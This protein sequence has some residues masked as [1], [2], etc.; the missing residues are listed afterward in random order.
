V[1]FLGDDG[2][3]NMRLTISTKLIVLTVIT[4]LLATVPIAMKSSEL[5]EEVSVQREE[6]GNLSTAGYKSVEIE[7]T[8]NSLFDKAKLMGS[9][10][11]KAHSENREIGEDFKFNFEKDRNFVFIEVLKVDATGTSSLGKKV[12]EDFLRSLSLPITYFDSLRAKS[13]FPIRSVA[14]GNMEIRNST[15]PQG[16]PVFT[17]GVPLVKNE[18]GQISHI[19]VAEIQLGALQKTFSERS[20][21]I[22]YL[23]DKNGILLAHQDESQTLSQTSLKKYPLVEKSLAETSPKR[24][25]R[26][27]DD[28]K[29]QWFIGAYSKTSYGITVLTQT[30]EDIILEPARQVKRQAFFITGIV[31]S[32]ALFFI[33]L[34]SMTLTSP[35]EK[36]ASLI[37]Q[38]SKGNF[39]VKATSQVNSMDEVGDLAKAFDQMTEGLKE[40]D[41][42]KSLFSKFHGSSVAED[43]INNDVVGTGG[44]SKDVTVF[45]SDIRGFT[46]FSEKHSPEEVVT[47]LNEYFAVM[48]DIINRNN[49]IVDKFIGDAIMAVWGAP[50][51]TSAD[52]YNAV[53][54]C[55]EMRIGLAKLNEK[56]IARGQSPI[57]IGMGLHSGKA[58]SGTI[59]SD[60]RLEYTVIGDTVNMASRIEASTKAFGVDLLISDSTAQKVAEKF[61]IDVAGSAEVKGKA[62]A[63]K[64]Y[65][66]LGIK[67]SSGEV[68]IITTPY[69]EYKSEK[70]D[71]VKVA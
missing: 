9:L 59:G 48:V 52:T 25:I 53:K 40:R 54:A 1:G 47:M 44:S 3:S 58:I 31:L 7:N 57:M 64:L 5:F 65:K 24:Q 14:L 67:K 23:I 27:F 49:G 62:E 18:T 51:S 41:K 6:Y 37:N 61:S 34:F 22:S 11:Y 4:L 71:K 8:L 12:R 13:S 17:I 28:E 32:A 33:F 35:I 63:L 36:L 45:F 10:I 20:E 15:M 56:R 46:A 68:D 16:A 69:S 66:V 50:K 29:G 26:F 19:V 2:E 43:L 21:K 39:E 38:V 55:I 30:S 42:V 60:E 70:V